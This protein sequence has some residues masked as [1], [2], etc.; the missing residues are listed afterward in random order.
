MNTKKLDDFVR[1]YGTDM[2]SVILRNAGQF[3]T[4]GG[5]RDVARVM[6]DA[7]QNAL[8]E[9]YQNRDLKRYLTDE[10]REQVVEGVNEAEHDMMQDDSWD[11][12]TMAFENGYI[13]PSEWDDIDLLMN[14]DMGQHGDATGEQLAQLWRED[15]IGED[16][17]DTNH[18]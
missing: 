12:A 7:L 15:K 8:T 18:E 9:A 2:V 13:Q 5:G 16:E 14:L 4:P 3:L 17:E 10:E 11:F 1:Q 6:A